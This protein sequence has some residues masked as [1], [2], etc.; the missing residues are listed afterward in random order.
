[1]SHTSPEIDDYLELFAAYG[2]DLGAIYKEDDDDRY[3]FLFAQVTRL[4][5]RPSPYNL[6]LPR[7]F[8]R[9]LFAM[10]AAMPRRSRIWGSRQTG[11]SC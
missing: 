6:A 11:T 2:R 8:A 7:R 9:P 1:M 3:A 10:L 4:L 5:V